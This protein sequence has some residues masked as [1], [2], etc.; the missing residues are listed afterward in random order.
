MMMRNI[1]LAL[2]GFCVLM[3]QKNVLV[4]S[5]LECEILIGYV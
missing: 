4:D 3:E 5:G 1:N 2:L